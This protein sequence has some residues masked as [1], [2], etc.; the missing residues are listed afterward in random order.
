MSTCSRQRYTA[1]MPAALVVEPSD[2]S[3]LPLAWVLSS[4]SSSVA[5]TMTRKDNSEIQQRFR[6][7]KEC[8][9]VR[10]VGTMG[11]GWGYLPRHDEPSSRGCVNERGGAGCW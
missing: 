4:S 6:A 7:E 5:M 10:V 1:S 8:W 2:I 9:G 3:C 11:W